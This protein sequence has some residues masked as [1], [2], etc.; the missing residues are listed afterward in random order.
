V[1]NFEKLFFLYRFWAIRL[2]QINYRFATRPYGRE[3]RLATPPL[4][5]GGVLL[6]RNSE[7]RFAGAESFRNPRNAVENTGKSARRA[8]QGRGGFL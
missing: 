4:A 2:R 7:P 8:P 1:H 6:L 5:R 3:K